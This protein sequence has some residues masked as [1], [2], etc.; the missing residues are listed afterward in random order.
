[1]S[2][3]IMSFHVVFNTYNSTKHIETDFRTRNCIRTEKHLFNISL[4]LVEFSIC[5]TV[6]N[7]L[8]YN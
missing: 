5:L 7:Y 4:C 3:Q 8:G 6:Q 1:M 2:L